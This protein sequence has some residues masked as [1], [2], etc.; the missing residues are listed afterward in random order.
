MPP[1]N[2]VAAVVLPQLQQLRKEPGREE[3][4]I[5]PHAAVAQSDDLLRPGAPAV[6][7]LCHALTPQEGLIAHLEQHPVTVPQSRQAQFDGVADAVIRELPGQPHDLRVLSHHHDF[8]KLLGRDG[9]QRPED[10]TPAPQLGGQL[11][12]PKPPG[13]A[14]GHDHT[15]DFR[16]VFH[17][18]HLILSVVYPL[19]PCPVNGRRNFDQKRRL[20]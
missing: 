12:F 11:I 6:H 1:D 2:G 8:V 19:S 15:T 20:A 3:A 13:V 9:F 4:G 10:E 18:H 14:G 17:I 5:A 7:Q 16:L